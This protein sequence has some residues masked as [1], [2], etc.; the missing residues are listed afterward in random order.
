MKYVSMRR[1]EAGPLGDTFLE[2][3]D[4][5]MV[6]APFVNNPGG[7]LVDTVF[8]F[9]THLRPDPRAEAF[10]RDAICTRP[11]L[12]DAAQPGSF[13]NFSFDKSGNVIA[14]IDPRCL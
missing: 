3:R 12:V 5:A 7:G 2:A 10:F 9:A 14:L 4:R 11:P 1:P 8:T 6:E 13:R